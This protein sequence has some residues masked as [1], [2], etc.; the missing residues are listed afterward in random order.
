MLQKQE[1]F[2]SMCG[3][4]DD[5]MTANAGIVGGVVA[6]QASHMTLKGDIAIVKGY[7]MIQDTNITGWAGK[8]GEKKTEAIDITMKIVSGVTGYALFKNDK[9]LFEE[10]NYTKSKLEGMRDEEV[11]VACNIVNA[12]ATAVGFP[13]LADYGLVAGD[14]AAQ[15]AAIGVYVAVKQMPSGKE[16]EK[17]VA[18]KGIA[19]TITKIRLNFD[20]MDRLVK[21]LS[22]SQPEFVTN[23]FNAREIYDLGGG[24]EK[25][26]TP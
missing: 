13:A 11:D 18:T 4:T 2:M 15:T 3:V 14:L 12:K 19:D 23:Y 20:I 22:V 7:Q 21:T 5:Y 1:N 26:P 17:Q 25:P 9:V 24:K 8:K 10:V 6:L 16:D